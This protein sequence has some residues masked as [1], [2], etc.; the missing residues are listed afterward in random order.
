M[1]KEVLRP[2]LGLDKRQLELAIELVK[3]TFSEKLANNLN[4]MKV[5]APLIL[6]RKS[7]LNDDLSGIEKPVKVNVEG[8]Q[9]GS[10]EVVQSLAKWKRFRLKQLDIPVG[11]GLYTNMQAL[12]QDEVLSDI[13]SVCV[14]QWDWEKHIDQEDRKIPFLK[15][16]VELIYNALYESEQFVSSVYSEISA[17]LPAKI[18][19]IH[20]E[21]L[22][23]RYPESSSKEREDQITKLY[24][25]VFIIGIG[26]VLKASG[27]PHDNRA[28][29]YDDWSTPSYKNYTGLNGDL[30]V[31]H[32]GL[33][34]SLELSS[35]GIRVD[36][37]ALAVQLAIA[38]Q[39]EREALPFHQAV[40]SDQVPLSIGG[41]IG[42]SRVVMFLLKKIHIGEVQHSVWT[43]DQLEDAVNKKIDFL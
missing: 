28:P 27:M 39:L 12:R 37:V 10:V 43:N 41:G 42:Q 3:S 13:H 20:S 15:Q 6:T 25:A 22:A 32:P 8:H 26:G 1:I 33:G 19:F 23:I 21:D 9:N 16:Q 24:G 40:L 31:W 34:R 17:S 18:H 35:M 11:H 30:L 5:S 38:N 36:R 2:K 14:D 7:G 29:D 4:L